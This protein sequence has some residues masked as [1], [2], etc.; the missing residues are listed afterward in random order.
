[1]FIKDFHDIVFNATSDIVLCDRSEHRAS[2]PLIASFVGF[3]NIEASIKF[4]IHWRTRLSTITGY[5]TKETPALNEVVYVQTMYNYVKLPYRSIGLYHETGLTD[6]TC[7][8]HFKGGDTDHMDVEEAIIARF[9][10]FPKY[11]STITK[12]I[13]NV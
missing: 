4:L 8:I 6:E 3:V 7:I 2:L 9:D 10:R 5:Q 11:K 1:M 12:Y 13:Q